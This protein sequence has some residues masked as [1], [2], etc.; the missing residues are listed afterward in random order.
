MLCF[1]FPK[2]FDT[3]STVFLFFRTSLLEVFFK[4]VFLEISQNSQENTCARVSFFDKVAGLRPATLFKKRLWH[5]CF[6]LNFMK[7]LR[8]PFLTEHLRWLLLFFLNVS[9]ITSHTLH[10]MLFTSTSTST[11]FFVFNFVIRRSFL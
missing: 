3:N 10:F 8:T 2:S 11:Y 6:P 1:L 4:K 5:M 9:F 7:F